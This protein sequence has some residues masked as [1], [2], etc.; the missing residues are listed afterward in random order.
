LNYDIQ[1][2]SS[3]RYDNSVAS[4]RCIIR[5]KPRVT[6]N[7]RLSR[8]SFD[9]S[10]EPS[11]V[12]ERVDFFG[13]NILELMIREPHSVLKVSL[14]A[15]AHV[16]RPEYPAA[17]LTP[18]WETIHCDALRIKDLS[19]L[20]PAH[21][22]F[23]SRHVPLESAV[24]AYA[25]ES[26]SLGRPILEAA[27]E[28]MIRINRDFKYDPEAT[29]VATPL[30]E[31][32]VKRGGVCQDFAHIMIAGLRGIGIPAAYVSGYIRTIP[33]PGEPRL[34]G[35]DASHAWI[36]VW[37]GGGIGWI[38]LDPTNNMLISDDHIVVA[39]GRDYADVSPIDGI[40]VSSGQQKL[41]VEVDIV[42]I[43]C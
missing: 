13:N 21:F 31:A 43:E 37:C 3:Y 19:P 6:H 14:S 42:P 17:A 25:R 16:Q 41:D 7:Q 33:P 39:S 5:L 10:P 2:V 11:Y 18:S 23:P 12:S 24:T 34:E 27:I 36:S 4:A 8:C 20:S 38:D 22:I 29:H 32:F 35:A 1:H 30:L 9:V 15:R 26:F 28:L 40:F